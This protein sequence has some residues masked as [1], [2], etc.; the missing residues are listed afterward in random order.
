MESGVLLEDGDRV[1]WLLRPWSRSVTFRVSCGFRSS[2]SAALAQDRSRL[3]QPAD[4]YDSRR[5]VCCVIYQ[6]GSQVCVCAWNWLLGETAFKIIVYIR[7]YQEAGSKVGIY[8]SASCCCRMM[9]SVRV[10]QSAEQAQCKKTQDKI[11]LCAPCSQSC[12]T[13]SNWH[14]YLSSS[15]PLWQ[16]TAPEKKNETLRII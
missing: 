14:L 15:D 5:G 1:G 4:S 6:L 2:L 11:Y 8:N 9:P 7:C 12:L 10:H 16:G 13:D 3:P